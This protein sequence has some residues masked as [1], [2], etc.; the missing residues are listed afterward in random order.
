MGIRVL[1]L[2]I[3]GII[4]DSTLQHLIEGMM[5]KRVLSLFLRGNPVDVG[6]KMTRME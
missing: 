4:C 2:K 3:H 5:I 1:Y 6:V